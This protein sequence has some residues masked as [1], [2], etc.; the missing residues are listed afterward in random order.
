MKNILLI[1][2]LL[3]ISQKVLAQKT[4]L[5]LAKKQAKP[6]TAANPWETKLQAAKTDTAKI[7]ICGKAATWYTR[8][9]KNYDSANYFLQK[10]LIINNKIGTNKVT[11]FLFIRFGNLAERINDLDKADFY[12]KQTQKFALQQKDTNMYQKAIFNLTNILVLRGFYPSAIKQSLALERMLGN[13]TQQDSLIRDALYSNLAMC[14]HKLGNKQKSFFYTQKLS[15]YSRTPYDSL[16]VFEQKAAFN[17]EFNN[18]LDTN[19]YSNIIRLSEKLDLLQFK[20]S[21]F[22]NL[23]DYYTKHKQYDKAIAIA[24]SVIKMAGNKP[25]YEKDK[26]FGY[27]NISEAYIDKKQYKKALQYQMKMTGYLEKDPRLKYLSYKQLVSIYAHLGNYKKAYEYS[28]KIAIYEEEVNGT[29]NQQAV[30]EIDAENA[31]IEKQAQLAKSELN[32]KVQQARIETE[33]QQKTIV[34]AL[35][36]LSLGLLLWALWNYNKQRQLKNALQIQNQKLEDK[37]QALEVKTQE[38]SEANQV[39]D[40]IFAVIG[41]DIQS[42][43]ADLSAITSLFESKDIAPEDVLSLMSPLTVKIKS[44]QSML[45]NLLHWA[46]LELKHQN[47]NKELVSFKD[48]TEKVIQQLKPNA[49]NK[50]IEMAINLLDYKMEANADEVEIAIRNIVSNSIK[51]TPNNGH[52]SL[53]STINNQQFEL[54]IKDSGVGIADEIL[55]NSYPISKLG[56]AGEKGVGLGL[57]VSKELIK[58]NGGSIFINSANQNGTT[59]SFV[60]NL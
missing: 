54:K 58:K 20:L 59:I 45:N 27:Q 31:A 47:N 21:L 56:T 19:A 11:P 2:L 13:K 9:K 34:I 41:H 51:F 28:N 23:S 44:L 1:G 7:R 38:L 50:N 30:A 10:G 60:F 35:L 22:S 24:Q 52:I 26:M 14:Y 46:L 39:K 32:A 43:V 55:H 18:Y 15:Q 57:R 36:L 8:E 49:D 6:R 53:E 48:I 40:K 16:F 37:T 25:E 12:Y 3:F 42:P 29:R 33:K 17:I 4:S 5:S